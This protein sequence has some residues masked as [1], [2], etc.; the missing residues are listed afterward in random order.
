MAAGTRA[1]GAA[2]GGGWARGRAA[3]VPLRGRAAVRSA[4]AGGD[5][6]SGDRRS[7]AAH[8]AS[9]S[10]W[11]GRRASRISSAITSPVTTI[12]PT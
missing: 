7:G 1:G 11:C 12:S 6:G 2:A 3:G 9:S 10:N 8:R 4:P 5:L